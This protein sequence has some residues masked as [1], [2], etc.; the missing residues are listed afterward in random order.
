[1]SE[2]INS[3][4]HPTLLPRLRS[5]GRNSSNR[6]NGKRVKTGTTRHFFGVSRD[7][8]RR[9]RVINAYRIEA[10]HFLLHPVCDAE[11]VIS[12]ELERQNVPELRR[13]FFNTLDFPVFRQ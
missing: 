11:C 1:M 13:A 7:L 10:T 2:V 6:A 4:P 5:S 8:N 9:L 3:I 12:R